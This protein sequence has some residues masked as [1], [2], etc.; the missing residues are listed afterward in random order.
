MSNEEF[1]Q[2]LQ[3]TVHLL[4]LRSSYGTTGNANIG[5]FAAL[6]LYQF[7]VQY[8]NQPGGFPRRLVNRDLTWEKAHTFDV[9][10]NIGFLN[11]IELAVDFYN[12]INKDILQDVPLSSATGFY[13]QTQNI[14]SVR[15]RGIDIELTTQNI[16]GAF[17]WDT[18]FNISLNRNEVLELYGNQPIDRGSQRVEVG[19]PLESWFMRDW[20]GVD[21]A[22]GD[23]QWLLQT[24]DGSTGAVGESLTNSYNNATRVFTGTS[25]PKFNGGIRNTFAYQ[26]FTLAAFMNFVYGN[27][28]YHYN[29]ELFDADGAYPTFNSMV[30][31]EG[32]SRWEKEGDIA[33]HPRAVLNG[34]KASNKISSRY[35]EDGSYLRL[36]NVTLSYDVPAAFTDK[37]RAQGLRVFVSGDN[38]FTWTNFSG[39]DPEV[40]ISSGQSAT[41]YPSSKKLMFG[42]NIDF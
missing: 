35:L 32:W 21:P 25:T 40:D 26:N 24:R 41:R 16:K 9:G 30:L 5:D 37:L 38:L 8:A 2:G 18:D 23:P 36:R 12:R 14:G 3:H 11:R 28:V 33:T 42:V 10:L 17:T 13:W 34:N 4:K 29:R 31:Q 27:K 19:R 39:I 6:D 20:R 15:N 7:D 1:F 22:N